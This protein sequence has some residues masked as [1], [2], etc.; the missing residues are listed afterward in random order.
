MKVYRLRW[1]YKYQAL[2]PPY[3]PAILDVFRQFDGTAIGR[4]WRPMKVEI[5]D[6]DPKDLALGDFGMPSSHIPV[7]SKRAV[8]FLKEIL[9]PN[10]EILP[11]QIQCGLGEYFAFNVTSVLDVLDV[12]ASEIKYFSSGEIMAINRYKL[13]MVDR[14]RNATIFKLPQDALISVFVT[15]TF[16]DA[17][18]EGKLSGFYFEPVQVS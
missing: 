11:I 17:V 18:R 5:D 6:E 9:T 1:D 4:S 14:L 7:F 10:G 2:V 12:D 16:V 3:D 15:E 13:R 8:D